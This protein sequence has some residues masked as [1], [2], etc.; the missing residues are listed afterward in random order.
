MERCERVF[1]VELK[2]EHF[3][4]ISGRC[5]SSTNDGI[6]GGHR[7][8]LDGPASMAKVRAFV[9][10]RFISDFHSVSSVR[11]MMSVYTT[12]VCVFVCVKGILIKHIKAITS[13]GVRA[14]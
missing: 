4:G 6:I 14:R 11:V 7:H 10:S 2:C 9:S 12:R 3:I 5:F 13:H 1:V 8:R